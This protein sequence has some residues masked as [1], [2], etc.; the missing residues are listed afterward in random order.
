VI[1]ETKPKGDLDIDTDFDPILDIPVKLNANLGRVQL[2]VQELL[3]LEAGSIL[4]LD[5]DVGSPI[6]LYVNDQLIAKGEVIL[7]NEKLGISI[8]DLVS[9]N[10]AGQE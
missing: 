2:S 7:I 8:L 10:S 9:D 1:D 4:E 3:G 5:K 6:D